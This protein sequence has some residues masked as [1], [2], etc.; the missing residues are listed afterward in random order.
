M[1]KSKTLKI[2]SV[3]C[4][5]LTAVTVVG[6]GLVP[7]RAQTAEA[8]RT[9]IFYCVGST[10]E[11]EDAE[12]TNNLIEAMGTDY[13]ENINVIVMTGGAE[14]WFTPAEY[15]SGAESI[16]PTENQ[17]WK[18]EGK[19]PGEEHGRML[20]LEQQSTD[21]FMTDPDTLTLFIDY[22]YAKYPA[23]RY[24][25]IMWDHGGGPAYGFGEDYRGGELSLGET[26]KAL[27]DS[28]LIKEGNIFEL[29][30]YDACLMGSMEITA[31]LSDYTDYLIDSGLQPPKNGLI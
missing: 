17:I 23:E 5:I 3:I 18:L 4:F 11:S 30:D 16:D 14:D 27:S 13:K 6:M 31:A 28:E 9:V 26:V 21:S 24:D 20:L 29:I 25:L 8:A 22:C 12:A 19:R 15:L 7:V 2:N 1:K 10:L